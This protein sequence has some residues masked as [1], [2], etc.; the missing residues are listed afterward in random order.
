MAEGPRDAA[1]KSQPGDSLA[2]ADT[3]AREPQGRLLFLIAV[4]WSLFQLWIVS[5]LPFMIGWGVVSDTNARA[6]HLAFALLLAYAAVPGARDRDTGRH[7]AGWTCAALSLGA[8]IWGWRLHGAGITRDAPAFFAMAVMLAVTAFG[9]FG[10]LRPSQPRRIPLSDWILALVA[11]W[12]AIYLFVNFRE[13]A[14]R[15]GS[16]TRMDLA[17]AGCGMVL[18]L[19]TTRRA[20][21]PPLMLIGVAFLRGLADED[22]P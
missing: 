2:S 11:A 1:I 20:L 13:L 3:G 9:I 22:R 15:P 7:L 4:S 21:G 10:V 16:P 14:N 19:E 18:L 12:C 8:L 6:V 17:V 5:P